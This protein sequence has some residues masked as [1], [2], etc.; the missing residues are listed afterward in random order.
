MDPVFEY[1]WLGARAADGV[2]AWITVGVDPRAA[3][4][5]RAAA[6]AAP[7]RGRV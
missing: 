3:Y 5:P 1:V 2:L 7:G 6:T 4:A